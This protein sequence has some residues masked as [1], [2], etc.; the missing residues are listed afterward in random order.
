M[1]NNRDS[2]MAQKVKAVVAKPDNLNSTGTYMVKEKKLLHVSNSAC[3]LRHT[4]T[5]ARTHTVRGEKRRR[6]LVSGIQRQDK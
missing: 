5:H 3:R 2:K 1:S 6:M 4:C